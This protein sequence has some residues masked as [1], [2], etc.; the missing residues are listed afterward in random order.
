MIPQNNHEKEVLRRLQNLELIVTHGHS[1]E[2]NYGEFSLKEA[3][4]KI[5]KYYVEKRDDTHR[6]DMAQDGNIDDESH[7]TKEMAKQ[8]LDAFNQKYDAQVI[9]DIESL[10]DRRGNDDQDV[11]EYD[12]NKAKA[13]RLQRRF[14]L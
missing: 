13:E 5:R 2:D 7:W 4:K 9:R 12:A 11:K 3:E 6:K 14:N 8:F 1:F 10:R